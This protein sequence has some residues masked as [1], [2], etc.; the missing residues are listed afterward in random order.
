[1]FFGFG[2]GTSHAIVGGAT[3]LAALF[4]LRELFFQKLFFDVAFLFCVK[5]ILLKPSFLHL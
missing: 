2:C 1:M 4:K 3:R 5:L